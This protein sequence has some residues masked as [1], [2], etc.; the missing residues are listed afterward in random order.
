MQSLVNGF[1]SQ[2]RYRI[3]LPYLAL[4]LIIMLIGASIALAL[5]A[6]SQ[7][8]RLTNQL[9]QV[10]RITADALSERETQNLAFLRQIAFAP[11]LPEDNIPA[12]SDALFQGQSAEL[13]RALISYYHVATL[14]Q[15]LDP[16][17]LIVFD[18]QGQALIDWL[19]VSDEPLA[20][21]LLIEGTNLRQ[22]SFFEGLINEDFGESIDKTSGLI[23][24][25]P[26]PQAY[27][28]TV[29]PIRHEQ[30]IIGGALLA[31][32]TERLL[33]SIERN[34][35]AAISLIYDLQG[36]ALSATYISRNELADLAMPAQI[37]RDLQSGAAQSSFNYEIYQR[38]FQLV[39]S[40]LFIANQHVGYFAVG[41]SRDYQFEP[42]SLSRNAI[43][44]ITLI[45]MLGS[46]LLGYRI[47]RSITQPLEQL[48]NTADQVVAG[49]LEQRT[50]ILANDELAHLGSAFNQMTEHLLRLYHTSRDLSTSI[51]LD[52]VLRLAQQTVD[53][54][55]PNTV[56]I[57][58]LPRNHQ[59]FYHIPANAVEQIQSLDREPEPMIQMLVDQLTKQQTPQAYQFQTPQQLKDFAVFK[60]FPFASAIV[61][62]I[63]AQ[64]SLSG[65]LF[66]LHQTPNIFSGVLQS[67][68][69]ATANM[70]ASV[71]FN[72]IL[73]E[74]VQEK[75]SE[76]QAIIQS[77][78]DGVIVCDQQGTIL[79]MNSAAETI[80]DIHDWQ[81]KHYVFDSIPMLCPEV[82][83]DVFGKPQTL[84]DLY[85]Y[86]SY[87]LRLTRS[88]VINEQLA[89][90]GE[91]II[92]HDISDSV[93]INRAKTN[94]IQVISHELR[95]PLTSIFG[96]VDLLL[97]GFGGDL[98]ETQTDLLNQ[99]QSRSAQ[100]RDMLNNMILVA[101][102]EADTLVSQPAPQDVWL[103]VE[104]V[105][106]PMRASFEAKNIEL[107]LVEL[108]EI[109]PVFIDRE[110]FRIILTQLIDNAYRYTETG[111][112][113]IS[114]RYD[115]NTVVIA[116][117]DTG[118]G[119]DSNNMEHL[120]TRFSRIQGSYTKVRGSGLGLAITKQLVE[121]QGGRVWVES[122]VQKGS[123]FFLSLPRA[124]SYEIPWAEQ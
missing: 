4:T 14:N 72:A 89:N 120:F 60:A 97:H 23:F 77:I 25:E 98:N 53:E 47:S 5:V 86:G 105:L 37:L 24:F 109:P 114:A 44:A 85:T 6:A 39:Y 68:L 34:T 88:P 80:L 13:Q 43:I 74:Q 61:T 59:W 46:I 101:N 82:Q 112:V 55:V 93:A 15:A 102:I 113:R 32:K 116:I 110:Q 2:I 70:I 108:G 87:S 7:E 42:V 115:V 121:R 50:E 49:N 65:I 8:E 31:I 118:M 27:F 35:F 69:Y 1:R 18:R 92:L 3:I 28:F 33:K 67:T 76:R 123:T 99:V 22:L 10:A 36:H 30:Q 48:V 78:G 106:S 58:L 107:E 81:S 91:V 38:P 83:N 56:V 17:R 103:S 96:N 75:A 16:D 119:I 62:P 57:A 66:F 94:F 40:P 41:L 79:L 54:F 21:P 29:V 12:V 20:E 122:E 64:D 19:R 95:T 104:N 26:D 11:A 45:L 73:F 124:E 100:M 117:Q 63:Q 84:P 52:E 90:T 51:K 71:L 9:A 111:S